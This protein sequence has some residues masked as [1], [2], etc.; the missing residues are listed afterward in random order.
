MSLSNHIAHDNA[1]KKGPNSD[2]EQQQQRRVF[3]TLEIGE[4]INVGSNNKARQHTLELTRKSI[5][6]RLFTQNESIARL[7]NFPD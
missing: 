5:I 2:R 4:K 3:I 7:L 6:D 1:R